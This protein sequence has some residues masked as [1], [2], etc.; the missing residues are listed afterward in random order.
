MKT[1][2]CVLKI[3]I[4]VLIFF[5]LKYIGAIDFII[6]KFGSS[7][8][9]IIEQSKDFVDLSNLGEE[10][11]VQKKVDIAGYKVVL[12]EHNASK[13]KFAIAKLKDNNALT[14]EDF[15][16]GKAKE[17]ITEFA[18]GWNHQMVR[19]ENFKVKDKC[20]IK[21]FGTNSPCYRFES[22]VVNFPVNKV[23]GVITV[24]QDDDGTNKVMISVN[25]SDKYSQIISEAFFDRLK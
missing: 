2:G 8:E 16:T 4:V 9:K 18:N 15:K 19:L 10:Y 13:Q 23:D 1:I 11:E 17:K 25:K 24:V 6:E 22:D 14:Q 7:Q 21:L 20:S 12:A 5:G 3:I